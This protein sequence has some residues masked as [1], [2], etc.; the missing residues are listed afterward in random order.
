MTEFY[1]Y[2]FIAACIGLLLW[3]LMRLERAY[4]YPFFM[5]SMFVS[6]IIPQ[7][8]V[9]YKNPEPA[10]PEALQRLFLMAFLCAV[11]CWVGYQFSPNTIW[12][13]KLNIPINE[14]KLFQGGI[15]LLI[16]GMLS[17]YSIGLVTIERGGHSHG[18]TGV[19]TILWFFGNLLYI[20]LAIFL[21][22]L[23]KR[24]NIQ[25]FIFTALAA[26]YPLRDI[27]YAGRRQPAMAFLLII[28]LCFWFVI[29]VR[30]LRMR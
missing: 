29:S 3:G 5:G 6:F 21:M 2:L 24:P 30:A 28:G 14:S 12:L 16:I 20:A 7:A 26:Y 13:N 4:Q 9:L 11:M 18:L 10:S 17:K 19:S 22:E 8:F 15:L 1:L 27:I 23:L 25:N